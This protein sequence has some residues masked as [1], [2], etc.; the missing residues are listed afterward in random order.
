MTTKE[1]I[2]KTCELPA[3]PMIA[4]KIIKLIDDPHTNAE[5]LQKVIIADQALATR[6]LRM[7]NSA[8]YGVRQKIDTISEAISIM[9]FNTIRILTLAISTRELYK[10]FGIIEQ[11][12]WE[13]SLG[14]SI[15]SGLLAEESPSLKK[16]EVVVAGLLHDI[17][18]V[19]MDNSQ[20][21]KFTLLTR[22]VYDERAPFYVLEQE[23]FGFGHAEAGFFLL[24]KWGF[25]V[26]LCN[27]IS[28]HHSYDFLLEGVNEYQKSLSATVSLADA[29]CAK[30]GIG[31]PD[32]MADLDLKEEPLREALAIGKERMEEITNALN[33][34]YMEEK[35]HY[36]Q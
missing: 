6:M 29:L 14:V 9:G 8:F 34:A 36:L 32:S 25:P 17:G 10:R 28:Q 21:E 5:D 35:I 20:P 18:K 7:A 16:E 26:R 11:K 12:L 33:V 2:F 23:V 27:V 3:V 24:E 31:Y 13:H 15:A 1:L 30:L 4:T 19:I 22:R